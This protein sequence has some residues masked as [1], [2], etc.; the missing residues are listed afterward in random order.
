M[1]GF[2]EIINDIIKWNTPAP[3]TY[4]IDG[5]AYCPNCKKPL[6]I[7]RE[8]FGET[9]LLPIMC[10]C[11][12]EQERLRK[13]TARLQKLADARRRCFSGDYSRLSGARIADAYLEHPHEAGIIQRYIDN[14]GEFYR[15]QQGLILYGQNGTGKSYLAAAL[16]NELI[17]KDHDVYFTTFTH[18][19]RETAGA[20][21]ER[22]AY[23]ESLNEY[24]LLVIDDLGAERGS[25]YMQEL[26]FSVIDARYTSGKPLVITTNL[27]MQDLKNP[28]TAQQSRIYDRI[29]QICY[30]VPVSGDSIRRK[31][32]KERYYR[33]KEILE[34]ATT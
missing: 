26:V 9:R 32:T 25:E 30:P 8:V 19:D 33:T 10:D 12:I 28:Q 11:E 29:L 22:Q 34:N 27:S 18:I 17:E 6:Q 14:F 31:D 24:A 16:C 23:F 3:G 2:Q 15:S 7:R 21:S 20:R 5:I 4:T 1:D 13:E